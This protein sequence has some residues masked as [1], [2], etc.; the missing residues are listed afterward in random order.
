V[1]RTK[2]AKASKRA[3]KPRAGKPPAK[4]A[5]NR[6]ALA[7]W[8]IGEAQANFGTLIQAAAREP[9]EILRGAKSLAV[10]VSAKDYKQFA[11]SRQSIDEMMQNSPLAAAFGKDRIAELRV[12]EPFREISL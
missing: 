10:V 1:A 6:P 5:Q 9:Q 3:P 2:A 12:K 7:R 8:Q 11:K 4:P